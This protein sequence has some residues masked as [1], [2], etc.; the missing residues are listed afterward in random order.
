MKLF[1]TRTTRLVAVIALF[2]SLGACGLIQNAID[3]A[4]ELAAQVQAQIEEVPSI[5]DM[6][7]ESVQSG[8]NALELTQLSDGLG[9]LIPDVGG[10]TSGGNEG[11]RTA[12][13]FAPLASGVPCNLTMTSLSDIDTCDMTDTRSEPGV[14]T[15]L[16]LWYDMDKSA[17]KSD[18]SI[19]YTKDGVTPVPAQ[20]VIDYSATID[21]QRRSGTRTLKDLSFELGTTAA[22]VFLDQI[23]VTQV[24]KTKPEAKDV[25][26]V[27]ITDIFEGS[28]NGAPDNAP[29]ANGMNGVVDATDTVSYYEHLVELRN[30][31]TVREIAN[32]DGAVPATR[33]DSRNDI[34]PG[35][36]SK[37]VKNP[38]GRIT[39]TTEE[40]AVSSATSLS[41][42]KTLFFRNGEQGIE[43]TDVEGD[44]ITIHKEFPN[45]K[46]VDATVDTATGAVNRKVVFPADHP[47]DTVV[48]EGTLT[49][50][51]AT[52]TRTITPKDGDPL[53]EKV[54]IT[55]Q[56]NGTQ[57]VYSRSN[58]ANGVVF[59]TK[60]DGLTTFA[61]DATSPA[62]VHV[63]ISAVV[64]EDG[65]AEM[66]ISV[67]R[68]DVEGN[69]DAWGTLLRD[70][71]GHITGTITIKLADGTQK[72]IKVDMAEGSSTRG[73]K[74]VK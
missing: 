1:L 30:G 14:T 47:L 24:L 57:V 52:L 41:A 26:A 67:D 22:D 5:S 59:V 27:G 12:A 49:D 39:Q 37:V 8:L 35:S 73:R 50:T 61:A 69:P 48:E 43:N 40:L 17:V 10:M 51:G 65:S 56:D 3:Q 13:A 71:D 32:P 33:F 18:G 63:T 55:K 20:H 58:G 38:E 34:V 7:A 31:M 64:Q 29:K 60:T 19:L 45:G 23:R 16:T 21:W 44:L 42:T 70:A 72:D 6:A 11:V 46:T 62:G 25:R 36:Y 4:K 74:K 66:K 2:G 68:P 15:S 28:F 9:N 53:V 54:T